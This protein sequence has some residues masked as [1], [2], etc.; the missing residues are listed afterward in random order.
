M[1]SPDGP[2]PWQT[3]KGESKLDARIREA[4]EKNLQIKDVAVHEE[5]AVPAE[6]SKERV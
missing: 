1:F 6:A 5:H 2:Y 3:K 4:Q